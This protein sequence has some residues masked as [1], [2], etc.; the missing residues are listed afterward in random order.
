[1]RNDV[2]V[3]VRTTTTYTWTSSNVVNGYTCTYCNSSILPNHSDKCH[4]SFIGNP[5]PKIPAN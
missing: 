3:R 2:S 4:V 5:S 1:M